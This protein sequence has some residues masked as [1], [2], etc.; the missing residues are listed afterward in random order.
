MIILTSIF[1]LF[2]LSVIA[3]FVNQKFP[4]ISGWLLGVVPASLF[5]V[6][7]SK[8][9]AVGRGDAFKEVYPW[10]SEL[11]I[12]LSFNLDGLSLFFALL[13]TGVGALIMIYAGYYMRSYQ[14]TNR[15][16]GY[17]VFFM[18]GMLGLVTASDWITLF[19]FWEFTSIS[20]FMLIGFKHEKTAAREAALQALLITGVGGLALLAGLIMMSLPYHS[21]SFEA[22]ISDPQPFLQSSLFVPATI[23][24]MIGAFTKSAIFPFHFWLPGAM[25]APSPV[26]AFLHS[27][28]MVKAGIY[29]LA[30]LHP[31]MESQEL[32]IYTLSVFGVVTMFVGAWF[33]LAQQDL[34]KIL[35][36]TTVSALGTMVL[37]IGT[38]TAYSVTAALVFLLVHA[39]YKATLFMMAGNIEKI[40]GTRDMN[41][42]GQLNRYMPVATVISLLALLSMSGIPPMIGFIGKE[43]MYEAK[44]NAPAAG[45]FILL[46]GFLANAFT[47]FV[48]LRFAYGV[49]WGEKQGFK[50]Q[51]HEPDVSLLAGPAVLVFI[52]LLLGIFP[53]Q[54]AG[55]LGPAFQS[56]LPGETLIKLKLWHGFNE[57]LLLSFLTVLLGVVMFFCRKAIIRIVSYLNGNYFNL[58]LSQ[59]FFAGIDVFLN[60]TKRKTAVVQHGYH[61]FYLMTIFIAAALLLILTMPAI[62]F[63]F[64]F[65]LKFNGLAF[66]AMLAAIMIIAGSIAVVVAQSRLVALIA[67]GFVGIGITIVFVLYSGVDLAITMVM[68]ETLT[69]VLGAMVVYHLPKYL[70]YSGIGSRI[71]DGFVAVF[72]GFVMG[73]LALQTSKPT[74]ITKISDY[75]VENSYTKAFGENIVNVILVDFR[76]LDTLGEIVV[77]ALAAIGIVSLLKLNAQKKSSR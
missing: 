10:L 37:L 14:K 40:T 28:T 65:D 41:Q 53:N 31:V 23:L 45:N 46:T 29:L 17:L 5:F 69:V 57:I 42:L 39:F 35:A 49:F 36:Y 20:S 18:A 62:D 44:L 6:F 50:K 15:F 8:I 68:V 60:L 12:G 63:Q 72:F 11:G 26:S 70:N 73:F 59:R 30:R 33:A 66:F 43:L 25:Q 75:F 7:L 58:K 32:W 64:D 1:I 77:L 4:K 9:P 16:F 27:A 76:A 47:V 24:I 3:P 22:V 54:I 13:V 34:K 2:G 71:R 21:F 52:S 55:L 61:R 56:I 51:P 74:P 48:S 38:S 19:M 67:T